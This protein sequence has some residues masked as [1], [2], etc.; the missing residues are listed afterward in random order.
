MDLGGD[1]RQERDS[2]AAAIAACGLLELS[3]LLDVAD[4]N[5]AALCGAATAMLNTL[6]A[7]YLNTTPDEDGILRGGT[8]HRP[9]GIGVNE[10][11]L[12]GDYFYTEALA[13]RHTAAPS[14]W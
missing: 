10:C 14:F 12:W 9:Q 5:R 2:S 6:S 13:R 1:P 11:C 3:G 7:H 8:Y 4:P